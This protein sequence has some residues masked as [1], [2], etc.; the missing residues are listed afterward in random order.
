ML[1]EERTKQIFEE[2]GAVLLND[3]FV[4][5]SGLHGSVYVNKDAV[6]VNHRHVD[7]LCM[8]LAERFDDAAMNQGNYVQVVVVPAIGAVELKNGVAKLLSRWGR[9]DVMS[10]YAQRGEKT[11]MTLG[12][13]S[14][15]YTLLYPS[16]EGNQ[17][18]SVSFSLG[19]KDSLVVKRPEFV[20]KR[21]YDKIVAGK[22]VL[23]I[24]DILTTGGTV[25]EVVKAV[26]KAGGAVVG[27]GALVNRGRLTAE[28]LG[29]PRLEALMTIHPEVYEPAKCPLCR[30]G[31]PYNTQ[32]GHAK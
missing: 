25:R 27:V 24:E 23:V 18:L 32:F 6:Y 4:Y 20:F 15:D 29:V 12:E 28:T 19:P 9:R 7:E 26:H 5:T 21:G 13:E 17:S 3:H 8:G 14:A 11:V 10:V 31:I 1:S 16:I 30:D 2:A 22:H